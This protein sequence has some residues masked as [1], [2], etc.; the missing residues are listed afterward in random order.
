[1]MDK[2]IDIRSFTFIRERFEGVDAG[3]INYVY[4]FLKHLSGV[5][6]KADYEAMRLGFIL[7]HR[8]GDQT[9]DFHK[10]MVYAYEADFKTVVSIRWFLWL[11]A[12]ISL[13]LNVAGWNIYFWLS[14][15]PIVFLLI[16]GTKLEQ[17]ITDLATY[18][19]QRHTVIIG[20]IKIQPSDEYF[21]FNKPRIV[22]FSI[23]IILFMN[24][25]G[26]AIFFWTLFKFNFNSCIMGDPMYA[27]SR[28]VIMVVVQTICS[29]STLPLYAIVTQ[30]GTSY[31]KEAMSRYSNA[32][33]L[34]A[35][36]SG[37]GGAESSTERTHD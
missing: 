33:T 34:G 3:K 37:H 21:W 11:F 19:A 18:L 23:H 12:V 5:V 1:R 25:F 36:V 22:L 31:N 32:S 35:G 7:A 30:M 16:V 9:F 14:F 28:L 27:I 29:Y 13:T 6:T 15:I 20:D 10:Y 2:I 26:F 4:S 17:V 8:N 24:S